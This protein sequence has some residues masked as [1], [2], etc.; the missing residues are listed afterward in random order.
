MLH[1]NVLAARL[2]TCPTSP[3]SL[4]SC[5]QVR[6]AGG[7]LFGLH[8]DTAHNRGEGRNDVH[9]GRDLS[10][11]CWPG[12]GWGPAARPGPRNAADGRPSCSPPSSAS[13]SSSRPAAVP[14][15]HIGTGSGSRLLLLTWLVIDRCPARPWGGSGPGR[16]AADLGSHR[17][18]PGPP[19]GRSSRWWRFCAMRVCPVTWPGGRTVRSGPSC[20]PAGYELSLAVAAIAAQ[21]PG[22]T[23]PDACSRPTC[24]PLPYH[25]A[26]VHTWPRHAWGDRQGAARA[27]R[28]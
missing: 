8:T 19:G 13:A 16:A 7:G 1:G 6:P 2:G 10:P 14:L 17:R 15:G 26:P 25:L 27:V 9:A 23:G 11:C 5:P 12:A 22:V 28:G 20:A 4:P 21:G 24:T 18:P 3:S